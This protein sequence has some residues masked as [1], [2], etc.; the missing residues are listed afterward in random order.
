MGGSAVFQPGKLFSGIYILKLQ[1][2]GCFVE[3]QQLRMRMYHMCAKLAPAQPQQLA[4]QGRWKKYR[5]SAFTPMGK[6]KHCSRRIILQHGA[7][8]FAL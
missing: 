2:V 4:K 6:G 7:N 8:G 1:R 5:I 3:F